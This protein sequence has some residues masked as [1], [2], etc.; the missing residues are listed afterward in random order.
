MQALI[1]TPCGKMNLPK[2]ARRQSR[3][4]APAAQI[5]ISLRVPG[6]EQAIAEKPF[7][8]F[9]LCPNIDARGFKG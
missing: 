3:Q 1:T 8:P 5:R 9:H 7:A 2:K 6:A 4:P